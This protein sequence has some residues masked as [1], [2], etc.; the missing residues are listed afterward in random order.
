M[1]LE[2]ELLALIEGDAGVQSVVGRADFAAWGHAPDLD[3]LPRVVLHHISEV[4]DQVQSGPT[5]LMQSRVQID[6]W[7]ETYA[8]A[9]ALAKAVRAAV[10]GYSGG[11]IERVIADVTSDAIETS[12]EPVIYGRRME[13]R[14]IWKEQ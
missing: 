4:P 13:L 14:A 11:V 9:V 5:A 2:P 10:D 12:A 8:Q 3:V 7:A 1:S 6:I